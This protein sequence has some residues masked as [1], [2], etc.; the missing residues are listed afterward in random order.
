MSTACRFAVCALVLVRVIQAQ[1]PVRTAMTRVEQERFLQQARVV[2]D[3]A[4]GKP[5]GRVTLDD[6][7]RT[8]DAAFLAG[9]DSQRYYRFNLA[10]YELDTL[11]GLGLVAPSVERTINGRSGS[12]TWWLD[13]VLMSEQARRRRA[14]SPPDAAKWDDEFQAVRVFD[15]LVANAYR[16]MSP[17]FYT[18]TLWDNLLITNSWSIRLIDHTRTFQT[19]RSLDHVES[20][21]RCDRQ[22]LAKLRALNQGALAAV[23][24]QYLTPEQL[25]ALDARRVLLVKHFDQ[26]IAR[27]GEA[28]VV[29]DLKPLNP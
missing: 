19:T 11:L 13:E 9:T 1:E 29:Y 10:A 28:A 26:R 22:L 14:I 21:N 7:T 8:H 27:L 2:T 25:D 16:N 3:P 18:S 6:G 15:E 24:S 23:L 12:L 17:A 5:P 4:T 20:L